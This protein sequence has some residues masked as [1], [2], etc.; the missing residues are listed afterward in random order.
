MSIPSSPGP[1]TV[2][3]YAYQG[4]VTKLWG[5]EWERA[6]DYSDVPHLLTVLDSIGRS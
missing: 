6:L 5:P 3:L 1:E 4:Q 2:L